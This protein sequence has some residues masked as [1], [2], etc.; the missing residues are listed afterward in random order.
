MTLWNRVHKLLHPRH[1]L[2]ASPSVDD[3]ARVIGYRFRDPN[4]L[5]QA[6]SH[7]SLVR[8]EDS[9]LPSNER[10]EFLGDSVL[11]LVMAHQ[12]FI[13]NP[14]MYEGD[15]TK[16]KAMLVSETALFRIG[17]AIGL[18]RYVLM[19]SDEE[20]SGGRQRPSIVSDTFE[21]VIGAIYLDG[22]LGAAR[23]AVLGCIY[24]RRGEIVTD[25]SQRTY[26]GELLELTQARGDGMPQYEIAGEFGPDH[27][28][29]F[30]VV[31]TVNDKVL[32]EGVGLSK[33][34]AEQQAARMALE[35]FTSEQQ[36]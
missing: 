6:L 14:A 32:G 1:D 5:R 34:E 2:A 29:T 16:L 24:S 26:K 28:K 31:V 9:S 23:Q 10:L 12:L 20:R 3:L 4:L 17:T 7:R 19:S 27:D 30:R 13:D 22:G 25:D 15:L 35:N 11:G 36:S 21:A 8:T 18:N 33:K